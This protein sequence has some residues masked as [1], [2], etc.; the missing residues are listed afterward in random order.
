MPKLGS[1]AMARTSQGNCPTWSS[2]RAEVHGMQP[3]EAA[4]IL[5][6]KFGVKAPP[7]PVEGIVRDLGISLVRSTTSTSPGIAD[8]KGDQATITVRSTEAPVRQRFTIAHELGHLLLHSVSRPMFRE[9]TFSGDDQEI[10]ANKFAAALLMPLWM[11]EDATRSKNASGDSLCRLFD[12]SEKAMSIRL[13][14]LAGVPIRW[15]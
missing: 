12:V 13:S 8:A 4:Q 1:T 5:L 9:T 3:R 15:G 14:Q 7:I 6:R 10:E 2:V 11:V